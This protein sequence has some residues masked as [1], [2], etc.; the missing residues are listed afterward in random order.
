MKRITE[1]LFVPVIHGAYGDSGTE[2]LRRVIE[3]LLSFYAYGD[4]VDAGGPIYVFRRTT[5][6]AADQADLGV[7]GT[8][9]TENRLDRLPRKTSRTLFIEIQDGHSLRFANDAEVDETALSEHGILYRYTAEGEHFIVRGEALVVENPAAI[10]SSIF[11]RPT[12]SSLRDALLDYR[13][14]LARTS[15]CKILTSAWADDK[16]L[17][18]HPGPEILLRD[19]L[20]QY[21]RVVLRDAEVR[22]EQNMDDRHPVDIK[23]TWSLT[24][25]LGIVEIKWLGKS[26]RG[27]QITGVFSEGRALEGAAQLADYLDQNRSSAPTRDTRG[28]LVIVDARRWG[29]GGATSTIARAEGMRYADAEIQFD[30]EYHKER[31]DFDPPIRMFVEPICD[32]A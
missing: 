25:R 28:Y 17:F 23:V 26:R 20:T 8:F 27:T 14:R 21:L 5:A 2:E 32:A 31:S 22:P 7:R 16:R 3:F 6:V 30:P 24:T 15:T 12:F 19:S 13:D 4:P 18:F 11:A 29:L 1:R 10:H 9:I